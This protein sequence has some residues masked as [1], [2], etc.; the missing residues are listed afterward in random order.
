MRSLIAAL[1]NRPASAPATKVRGPDAQPI[2][3][4]LS[5]GAVAPG[6]NFNKYFVERDVNVVRRLHH[7]VDAMSLTLRSAV[8]SVS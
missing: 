4:G 6:W 2:F 7:A 8:E 3:K 1:V 5:R